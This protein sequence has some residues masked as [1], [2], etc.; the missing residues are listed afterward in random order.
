MF[1][2][3]IKAYLLIKFIIIPYKVFFTVSFKP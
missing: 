1:C 3:G 2:I